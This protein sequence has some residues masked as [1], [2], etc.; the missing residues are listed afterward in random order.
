MGY[1]LRMAAAALGLV[2]CGIAWGQPVA[3][4]YEGWFAGPDG[5]VYVQFGYFNPNTQEIVDTPIGPNNRIEPGPPDQVQ[6]TRF[7]AGRR[8]GV[9]PGPDHGDP[10][11]RPDRPRP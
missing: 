7:F 4:V 10:A 8:Y 3:P 5:R 1:G 6:P 9:P 2:L 11:R